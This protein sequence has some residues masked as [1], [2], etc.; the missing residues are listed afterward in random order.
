MQGMARWVLEHIKQQGIRK[1]T[2][3]GHSMGGKIA[4]QAAAYD[5]WAAVE[6]LI[7]I[8]PSPPS[9][10][11]IPPEEKERM[12]C[13]PNRQEAETTVQKVTIR[14]LTEEQYNLAI[15][16]QLIADRKTWRWWITEGTIHSIQDQ[17]PR[18]HIP[19]TIFASEDDPAISFDTI[20]HSVVPA[21]P[22]AKLVTAKGIGHL[23]PLEAPE[24]VVL[25]TDSRER[26]K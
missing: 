21:L 2:L 11:P 25:N 24:W 3:I 8:A 9:M 14:P 7:L 26:N 15:A 16:T 12:L 18:I 5:E 10:E 4:V 6:R 23:I 22:A 20:Q 17:T 13:H 1:Y 19:V